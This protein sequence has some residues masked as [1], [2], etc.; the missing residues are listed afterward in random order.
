MILLSN[1]FIIN[2]L[3]SCGVNHFLCDI[4]FNPLVSK[5]KFINIIILFTTTVESKSVGNYG[6]VRSQESKR[7]LI[8]FALKCTKR[9]DIKHIKPPT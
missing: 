8:C 9:L 4:N 1:V 5:C 7:D 3:I 6:K 2:E